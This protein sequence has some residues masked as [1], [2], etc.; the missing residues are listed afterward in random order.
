MA[1]V[2]SV[3]D[4]DAHFSIDP[5]KR[6]I[7]SKSPKKV[8]IQQYDHNSERITFE[9]EQRYVDGHD[10]SECNVVEIHY[11]NGGNRGVYVVDDMAV[12]TE[13]ADK[14]IC[15]WLISRNATQKVAPLAFRL[16]F[17]CVSEEE[18]DYVWSTAVN[19]S[20]FVL[21]GINGSGGIE[22]EYPDAISQ[23][24]SKIEEL[25]KNSGPA[26]TIGPVATIGKVTLTAAAWVGGESP[27]SQIV[28]IDGVTAYSQVDLT[29]SVEQLA[30]FYDKDLTFVTENDGGVVTVY[31]IGQK[32]TN[33]YTIQ[34][35]IT[36][37]TI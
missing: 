30:I 24:L 2:H 11:N 17:K 35:T 21:P 9:L 34:V 32:P 37:V 22:E 8:A 4:S 16:T 33:D 18:E 14:V 13:D 36:E 28:K 6:V 15:S 19:K 10:M 20:I 26:A 3:F 12:S 25:I 29:P 23:I 5:I 1:H 7:K 31:A 27:Y